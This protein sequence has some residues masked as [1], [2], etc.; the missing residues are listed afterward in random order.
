MLI[1]SDYLVTLLLRVFY[2]QI[3]ILPCPKPDH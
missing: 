1:I 3:R 2:Y